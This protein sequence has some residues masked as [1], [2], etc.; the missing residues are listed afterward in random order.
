MLIFQYSFFHKVTK[1][2]VPKY[3]YVVPW[4]KSWLPTMAIDSLTVTVYEWEISRRRLK[5]KKERKVTKMEKRNQFV[6]NTT[7]P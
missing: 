3:I 2:T 5:K 4:P 6:K 7:F 1:N